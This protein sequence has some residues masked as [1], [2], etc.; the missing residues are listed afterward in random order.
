VV[1]LVDQARTSST[2]IIQN[3]K[4]KSY[5]KKILKKWISIPSIR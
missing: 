1:H 2:L 5:D 3:S 4:H